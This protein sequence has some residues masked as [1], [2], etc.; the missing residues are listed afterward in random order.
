MKPIFTCIPLFCF[1]SS[2]SFSAPNRIQTANGS[3]YD[4]IYHR[5]SFTL[6]PASSGAITNG[7]VTTYF[8]TTVSNVSSIEFDLDGQ[9]TV[10]SATY[11]GSA[12]AKTQNTVTDIVTLTIPNIAL[13]G[14]LDSVTIYYSGT[15]SAPSTSIPSGYNYVTHNSSQKAIYTLD[16]AFTAHYWWPCK[17]SLYDKIDSCTE[18]VVTTPNGYKVSANGIMTEQ[19]GA[20]NTVTT[21]KT[22]YPIATY[23]INFACANYAVNSS[24]LFTGGKTL[25]MY[26][27]LY[28]EDNGATY[29]NAMTDMKNMLAMYASVFGVDYP[30]L[31]E[32]YGMTECTGSW[33]ALEVQSMTFMARGNGTGYNKSTIA[34]ELS[35]QWFGDML[36]TNTWHQIWLNEGFAQYCE[37]VIYPENMLAVSSAASSRSNLKSSVNNTSTTYVP[38]TSNADKIFFGTTASQPYEKGAMIL[39]MLRSW[40]GDTKFFLALKNYLNA[41]GLKYKF[42]SVDSLQKYMQAQTAVDLTSFFSDW[43]N[44]KGRVTFSVKYQFV[45]NG[46]YIQ[47]IQS[48]TVAG[49]GHFDI[50]VPIRIKNVS[51]LDTTVV[52]IDKGSGVLYNNVTGATY[53]SST[54]YYRLS[55]TPT[56]ITF[57]PNDV[58]LATASSSSSS[59][60]LNTLVLPVKDINLSATDR[61]TRIIVN[62]SVNADEAFQSII[63]EK[64]SNA[65]DFVAVQTNVPTKVAANRY[66]GS[67]NDE[68]KAGRLYYRLK[69]VRLDGSVIYSKLEIV[70]AFFLRLTVVPNPVH[71]ALCVT[72]PQGFNDDGT[73]LLM[74]NFSGQKMKE[75]KVPPDGGAIFLFVKEFTPGIYSLVLINGRKEKLQ[76][77]FIKE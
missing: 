26:N 76:T 22:L 2:W 23:G 11:H 9:M 1:I 46:V 41:P 52:I 62:W 43:V 36:T 31:N 42:S 63:L 15:P 35:H 64:S 5:I 45:T 54:I 75:K 8:R 27:Y 38:D 47:L 7:S 74:Y 37:S 34:H 68:E 14:T 69:L 39:S 58:V 32:Q 70:N 10:S 61:G 4:I 57:D 40:L 73:R 53:S 50:P 49:Q 17:E 77:N 56:S 3:N 72:L 33:G 19:V 13:K 18:L 30:F 60:S 25:N 59:T 20:T 65:I 44:K 6:N 66:E 28:P 55:Q 21:W 29:Q 12:A 67:Y 71:S 51:G 24:T 48:P 16:E